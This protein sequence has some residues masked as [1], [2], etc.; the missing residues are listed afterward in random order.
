MLGVLATLRARTPPTSVDGELESG[1]RRVGDNMNQHPQQVIGDGDALVASIQGAHEPGKRRLVGVIGAPG[2]GKT[3]LVRFL[4]H[5]VSDAVVGIVPMDG[6]HLANEVLEATGTAPVQRTTRHVRRRRTRSPPRPPE[7][8]RN[9]TDLR[10]AIPTA[11]IEEPIAGAIPVGTD[12]DLV[13][14]EGNYLLLDDAP[15][16]AI[17]PR[18][19]STYYLDTPERIRTDRL[20][21]RQR[22]TYGDGATDW[23]ER[24]DRPNAA[25]VETT[26]HRAD[27]I[28]RYFDL[29]GDQLL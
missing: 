18:L 11:K 15:W 7:T 22:R 4:Q 9:R 28:V 24:V 17:A 10:A 2:A 3:H 21:A 12:T 16:D 20:V 19:D 5:A 29:D 13:I 27:F 23:I 8:P 25:I 6:F 1:G 14:V 26:R